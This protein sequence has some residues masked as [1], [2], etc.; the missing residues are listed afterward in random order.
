[1]IFPKN[2]LPQ[3]KEE[4]LRSSDPSVDKMAPLDLAVGLLSQQIW[5]WG[6]DILRSEGNWLVEIGFHRQPPPADRKGCSSVYTQFL[7]GGRCIVLRG[8][9]VFFGDRSRGGVFLPR[10]EFSPRYTL[11]STLECPPWFDAELPI[12]DSPSLEQRS[13]CISLTLELLDWIRNY[14]VQ[15]L[16]QLGLGYRKQIIAAWNNG[17]HFCSPT[18]HFAADWRSLANQLASR[19]SKFLQPLSEF[20]CSR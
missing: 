14:E 17:K 13:I 8:F 2:G 15:V 19:P 1:M 4:E 20:D 3:T 5:C 9:G 7:P 10:Y 11:H 6:R 12:L 16:Q 18:E